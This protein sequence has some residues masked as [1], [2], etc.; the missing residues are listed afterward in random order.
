MAGKSGAGKKGVNTSN[1]PERWQKDALNNAAS[2]DSITNIDN[3]DFNAAGKGKKLSELPNFKVFEFSPNEVLDELT[4]YQI[5]GPDWAIQMQSSLIKAIHDIFAN[6]LGFVRFE[7]W[8]EAW[9]E[10]F[11]AYKERA[12]GALLSNFPATTKTDQSGNQIEGWRKDIETRPAYIEW[13]LPGNKSQKVKNHFKIIEY[14]PDKSNKAESYIFT[15]SD[16]MLVQQIINFHNQKSGG[17]GG[18]DVSNAGMVRLTGKP[19]ILLVFKEKQEDVEPGWYPLR[20]EIKFRLINYTDDP[21]IAQKNNSLKLLDN[22][23]LKFYAN[24]IKELFLTNPP[25]SFNKGKISVSV[26]DRENG[27]E[28]YTYCKEKTDGIALYTKIYQILDKQ[29]DLKKIHFSENAVPAE[30]FPTMPEEITILGAKKRRQRKR[31]IGKVYFYYADLRIA[32]LSQPIRLCDANG[33]V[34][35]EWKPPAK[36]KND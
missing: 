27:I 31:P 5:A 15:G 26:K 9:A 14:F 18:E 23:N 36:W 33:W 28:N 16:M 19:E 2:A 24:K 29:I 25:F 22:N 4:R 17:V 10:G 1:G 11:P 20:A 3:K 12:K 35:N 8:F 34:L 13:Q 30:A 6:R 7:D 32:N 21:I